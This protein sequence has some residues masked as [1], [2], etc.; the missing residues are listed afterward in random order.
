[1]SSSLDSLIHQAIEHVQSGNIDEAE[2]L[3]KQVLQTQAQSFD[4]LHIMGVI[5]VLQKKHIAAAGFFKRALEINPN[6]GVAHFNLATAL[7]ESGDDIASLPHHAQAV[8]LSPNDQD[9]WVN[10]GRSLSNLKRRDGAL[11]CY[12]N[13]LDI[14]PNNAVAL[15]NQGVLLVDLGR[16][17]EALPSFEKALA[18]SPSH[19]AV[20]SNIGN[21]LRNLQRFEEALSYY[22]RANELDPDCADTWF[23]KGDTLSNLKRYDEALTQYDRVIQLE[24]DNVDAWY[25]KA[26]ILSNL[27]R[28]DEAVAHFDQAIRLKPDRDFLCGDRLSAKMAICDWSDAETQFS[29]LE[30][31]IKSNNN[32]STPFTVL[33]VNDS[34]SLQGKVGEQYAKNFTANNSLGAIPK[35]PL[36]EK[37]RVGYFSNDFHNHAT[38]FLAVGLFEMHDRNKF[39]VTAFS[40]GPEKKDKMRSRLISAFDKFID[41]RNK[42]DQEI[43]QLS[44]ELGID[45]AVDLQGYQ[46]S[47][48]TGIFAY[49][50]APIQ[51]N[52][53]AYPGTMGAEYMDYI[54]ADQTLIPLESQQYYSEKVA[55]LPS[56]YQPNDRHRAISD[57]LFTRE[58]FGLPQTGFVFCCF[59][60]NYKITPKVFDGWMNIL[61]EVHGSVLWLLE[62]SP[63][64]IKN[65]QKEAVTRGVSSD[66]LIFAKLMNLPEHLARH[67]MAD[68]FLDTLPYNAHTTASDALWAGLPVLTCI[69][70][71]FPSRVAASLLNAIHLPELIAHSQDDYEHLAIELATHPVKL[72]EIKQKLEYNRLTTPLFDTPLYTK[73]LEAAYTAMYERYQADLSPAHIYVE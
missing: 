24:P 68:L 21:T 17:E 14:N 39:E 25:K 48:R 10:Y 37:I 72:V 59:N 19:P 11:I 56:T 36:R 54:V 12:E 31:K 46:T 44:R 6:S 13:A 2:A 47:L 4:A 70:Q 60:A 51:V 22:G 64:A 61:K 9:A 18:L 41:V 15:I 45:I 71:S 57:R 43:A 1:M 69:G 32:A 23:G 5:E 27:K 8:K 38:A 65:L 50:T 29:E 26:N 53:L 67:R 7:S 55:Y 30:N 28:Y 20:L 73:H 35:H 3:L 16:N 66:R 40:F 63:I 49:G 58:E 62:D 33:T 52:Y 34:P 42:S